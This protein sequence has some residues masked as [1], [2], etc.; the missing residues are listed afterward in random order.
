M[1]YGRD[2]SEERVKGRVLKRP[3]EQGQRAQT[4]ERQKGKRA[5]GGREIV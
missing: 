5:H 3:T 4:N 1:S 2:G